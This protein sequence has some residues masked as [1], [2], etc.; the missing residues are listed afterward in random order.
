MALIDLN[1]Y[2]LLDLMPVSSFGDE[3]KE[4][5]LYDFSKSYADY[6]SFQIGEQLKPQ[7]EEVLESLLA[8]PMLEPTDIEDFFLERIKD[9][10]DF[11]LA[12]GVVFKKQFLLNVY[13]EMLRQ[14]KEEKDPSLPVWLKIVDN[15]GSDNWNSVADLIKEVEDQ[16]NAPLTFSDQKSDDSVSPLPPFPA[17]LQPAI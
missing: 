13:E 12:A 2:D 6:I 7:D 17:S 5:Y 10:D 8:D 4:N 15:A 1:K 14:V 3:I 16:E 11:L 9:F